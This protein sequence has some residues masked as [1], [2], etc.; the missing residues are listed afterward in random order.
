MPSMGEWKT[1]PLCPY[2]EIIYIAEKEYREIECKFKDKI[3]NWE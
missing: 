2:V 1:T 3:A